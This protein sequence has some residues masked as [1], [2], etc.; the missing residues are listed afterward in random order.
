MKKVKIISVVILVLVS[1]FSVNSM[2]KNG[3]NF[4]KNNWDKALAQAKNENK[5]IFVDVYA[6]WCGPCRSLSETT[7]QNEEVAKYFNK[8]FINLKI[9]G[10]SEQSLEFIES[11]PVSA[12]PTLY[13]ISPK[14]DIVRKVTGYQDV[15][16]MILLG[17]IALNPEKSPFNIAK[18]ELDSGNYTTS[19]LFEYVMASFDEE[20]DYSKQAKEYLSYYQPQDLESDSVFVIFVLG[21]SDMNSSFSQYF[22]KNYESFGDLYG[23]YAGDKFINLVEINVQKLAQNNNK[24]GLKDVYAFINNAIKGDEYEEFVL[25]VENYYD[26]LLA[27]GL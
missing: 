12:Y 19:N 8:H 9:D 24:E 16:E 10:D 23:E 14:G 13:F 25:L 26:S 4:I 15:D 1:M 20:I 7:F 27:E 3:V 22:G 11:Y 21:D 18:R 5:I 6:D 2:A 17:E